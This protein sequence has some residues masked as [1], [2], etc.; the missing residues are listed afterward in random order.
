MLLWTP[1]IIGIVMTVLAA[2]MTAMKSKDAALIINGEEMSCGRRLF[3]RTLIRRAEIIDTVANNY[4]YVAAPLFLALGFLVFFYC[5]S[6]LYGGR[7]R[8]LLFW[9]CTRLRRADGAVEAG[10]LYRRPRHY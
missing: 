4:T 9:R 7:G 10:H 2:L 5:L 1:A 8:S 3:V 6:A